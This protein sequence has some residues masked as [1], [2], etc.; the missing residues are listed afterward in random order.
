M[1]HMLI[2]SSVDRKLV[3]QSLSSHILCAKGCVHIKS[4]DAT[5]PSMFP[6]AA[7]GFATAGVQNGSRLLQR[8]ESR[9]LQLFDRRTLRHTVAASHISR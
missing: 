3:S 4:G 6:A 9:P 1:L 2:V 5:N 7:A 8:T